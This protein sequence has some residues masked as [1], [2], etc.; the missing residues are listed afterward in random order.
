VDARLL[1]L[2]DERRAELGPT[3]SRV[4]HKVGR[5]PRVLL[6]L[7]PLCLAGAF[8]YF[9]F[10]GRGPD[11]TSFDYPLFIPA[12]IF[13]VLAVGIF[14]SH[15]FYNPRTAARLMVRMGRCACCARS[16]SGLTPGP[17]GCVVCSECG[18]SWRAPTIAQ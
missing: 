3:Y 9:A 6:A 16:L 17:D 13:L 5:F 14:A 12:A 2:P 11:Y 18:A 1:L 7:P 15:A 4:L 8:A 10:Q